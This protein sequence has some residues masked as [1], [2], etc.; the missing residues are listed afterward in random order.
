MKTPEKSVEEIVGEFKKKSLFVNHLHGRPEYG[1]EPD[2][3]YS[4]TEK[5]LTRTLQTERQK[6]EEVV[7]RVWEIVNV[8]PVTPEGAI[9]KA[10]LVAELQAL[11]NPNNK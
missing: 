11:T 7:E 6:R 10:H 9:S 8:R 5:E 2:T 4:F 3:H 1:L